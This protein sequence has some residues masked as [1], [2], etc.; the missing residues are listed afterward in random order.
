MLAISPQRDSNG[1]EREAE[2]GRCLASPEEFCNKFMGGE[3]LED[4]N[5]D[6][7]FAGLD[8]GDMLPDLEVDPVEILAA[9][10]VPYEED[11]G[12]AAAAVEAS[13]GD[14]RENPLLVDEK[15]LSQAEE[16]LSAREKADDLVATASANLSFSE[17][18]RGP[19]TSAKGSKGKR[20]VKVDWTPELHRRFVQVVEQLGSD[21]AVPS[22]ILEL[23]GI[24]GLTRHNVASHLQK[25]RAHRKHLL[26]REV[27]T[28]RWSQRWHMNTGGGGDDGDGTKRNI[29]PWLLPIMGF[30]PPPVQPLKPL[31]VWGHPTVD[32][33]RVLH[34]WP[35]HLAPAPSLPSRPWSPQPSLPPPSFCH[36]HYSRGPGDGWVPSALTQ[37]TPCFPQPLLTARFPA[38]L[39]LG[40]PPRPLYRSENVVPPTTKL[41]SSLL[42]LDAHPKLGRKR[43]GSKL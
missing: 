39:V 42:S 21:K 29:N 2:V 7:L 30:S 26:A 15:G 22:R 35:K 12:T 28:A 16:V 23:M 27:E 9:F 14:G 38:P 17:A 8:D 25:Y 1:N 3:F 10:S 19:K 5:F 37:G 31:H 20:K 34:L 13:G 41:S 36:T 43:N 32:Q 40:I 11:S 24:D 6:D 33:S 18:D 4:I